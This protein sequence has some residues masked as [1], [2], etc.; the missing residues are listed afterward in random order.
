MSGGEITAAVLLGSAAVGFGFGIVRE[1]V[2]DR[3]E[4]A[5]VQRERMRAA[6]ERDRA[7][8]RLDGWG[9]R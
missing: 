3:R 6:A 9:R 8:E 1:L 2:A 4:A 7:A 5:A